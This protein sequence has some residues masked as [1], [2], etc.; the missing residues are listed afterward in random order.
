M[1]GSV[2]L[3]S[4]GAASSAAAFSW[5]RTGPR[6]DEAPKKEKEDRQAYEY[7]MKY[8]HEP[9]S[10]AKETDDILGHYDLRYYKGVV[11][12]EKKRET[13][14][15]MMR[16]YLETFAELELETW[17]AHGTLLGW[18]WNYNMLPWDW[19]IDTQVTGETLARMGREFNG[20]TYE[21]TADPHNTGNATTATYL[22]DVNRYADE[23]V[24]GNGFNIIDARWIN[25][26]N[27][28]FIDITG[29][30][31]TKPKDEPGVISCKNNHHYRSK[32]IFPLRESEF[33]GVKALVPRKYAKLLMDEYGLKAL[34]L[35]EYEGHRWDPARRLW[36][37][38]PEEPELVKQGK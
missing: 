36:V 15:H 28:L 37:K 29:L 18:W 2:L 34:E 9:I 20:T 12:Y 10:H 13:Q 1:R 33:E 7:R 4:L 27:G 3:A 19:D 26:E 22:M 6:D 23:R 25:V 31:E 24:R 35:E 11:E 21:F 30:S 16:A 17:L 32:D 38:K 8:F 5:G 14:L